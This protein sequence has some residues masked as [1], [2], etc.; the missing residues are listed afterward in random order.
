MA[1]SFK[2]PKL[3]IPKTKS[4]WVFDIIG[5][6]FYVGS[7]ILLITVWNSLPDEVP[8]H[9]NALGEVDRFGSKFELLILPIIGGF[10]LL[11]MQAF[12]KFPEIHNYPSRINKS[13]AEQFYLNSRK[14]INQ[15]KNVCLI[16]FSL[17]AFESISIALDWNN[18]FGGW[19]MPI[20][21]VGTVIPIV[22][23]FIRQR[24]IK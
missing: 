9:Y 14:M 20:L 10:L 8:A 2:L 1:T 7:I 16:L 23:L 5:L 19:F 12:E 15:L 11:M 4:E 3:K 13:N 17:L 22:L 24:K 6:I 18:G 21:I